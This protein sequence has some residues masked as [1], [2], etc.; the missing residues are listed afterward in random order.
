MEKGSP[1]ITRFF[2]SSILIVFL[3]SGCMMMGL[4]SVGSM[5]GKTSFKSVDEVQ[6]IN[7]GQVIDQLIEVA[8]S[9]LSA[10]SLDIS[11]IAVWKI[12]SQTAGLDV[13]VIRQKIIAELVGINR[14]KVISR[15]RLSELLEEHS[16]SLSGM[17]NENSAVEFGNLFGVDGFIDGYASIEN[18]L[19]ILSFTL[20]ETKSGVIIWAKTFEQPMS[21]SLANI[22]SD[23]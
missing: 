12:K 19:L 14:F 23:Q 8:V 22:P 3:S 1:G 6:E 10:H 5:M 4:T 18:G 15:E 2:L 11:S 21:L 20:V 7:Q 16:L 17:I 9:D 13:E